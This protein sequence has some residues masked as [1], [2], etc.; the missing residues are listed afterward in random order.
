MNITS[1]FRTAA[2]VVVIL[3]V[4]FGAFAPLPAQAQI[5]HE[6]GVPLPWFHTRAEKLAR[7]ACMQNLPECRDSVRQELA[8]ELMITTLAPWVL[9]LLVILGAVIYVRRQEAV[10]EVRRHEAQ[11][12]HLQAAAHRPARN[13]RPRDRKGRSMETGLGEDELV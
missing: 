7:Q 9:L 11:R 5:M 8:L 13:E 4:G 3:L 10:R 6:D 12:H 1:R 2:K